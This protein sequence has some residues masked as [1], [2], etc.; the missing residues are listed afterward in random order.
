M[1]STPL[2]SCSRGAAT[3]SAITCGLAPGYWARTTTVGGTTS[4]Y[5]EMGSWKAEIAP[6]T[7]MTIEST[8]AKMGRSTKKRAIFIA[9]SPSATTA[10]RLPASR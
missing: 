6:M 1:S 9:E 3:V 7:K 2:I 4:G 8:P 5:S 10:S